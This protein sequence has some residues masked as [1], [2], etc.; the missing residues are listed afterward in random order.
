MLFQR[1]KSKDSGL[2]PQNVSRF[3][4]AKNGSFGRRLRHWKWEL[5]MVGLVPGPTPCNSITPMNQGI[6]RGRGQPT[7]RMGFGPG[8]PLP[9]RALRKKSTPNYGQARN[10]GCS[11][12]N[13]LFQRNRLITRKEPSFSLNIRHILRWPMHRRR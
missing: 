9:E 3:I 4:A 7:N 6:R 5:L 12:M 10:S 1:P 13:A 11:S 2:C 8:Q